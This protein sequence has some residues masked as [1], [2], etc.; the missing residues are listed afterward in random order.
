AGLAVWA[1]RTGSMT[2]LLKLNPS[3]DQRQALFASLM[4]E[5]LFWLAI[6][7]CGYVGTQVAQRASVKPNTAQSDK[8]AEP[9]ASTYINATAALIGSVLIALICIRLF[10]QDFSFSDRQ[11][12]SVAAQPAGPQIAFGVFVSFGIAAFVV[13]KFLD[14]S[15]IWPVLASAL[16]TGLANT[17]YL[18]QYVIST[19]QQNWPPV[20]FSNPALSILP[21]Q[22][23]AFGTLGSVA[24]YWMAVRYID[25]RKHS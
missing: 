13:K 2:D 4:W 5:P 3:L 23:V 22:M 21:L 10:A 7:A 19:L 8:K 16:I 17:L 24:G 14:S 1:L 12:G 11:L 25:W 20:F 9:K 15:Y 6:V 18:K